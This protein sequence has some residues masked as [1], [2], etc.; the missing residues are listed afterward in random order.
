MGMTTISATVRNLN[1]PSK[2]ITANFLVDTGAS[3]TVL[4]N[5][6]VKKL[7]LKPKKTQSFSLADGTTVTRK[8]GFA[9]VEINGDKSPSMVVLGE[10]NDSPLIGV[11]TLEGMGLMVHPFERK[12]IPMRL[13]LG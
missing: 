2:K 10:K 12:L 8:L 4:P 9:M 3:F 11:Y 1:R 6:F 7:G 13:M 5:K